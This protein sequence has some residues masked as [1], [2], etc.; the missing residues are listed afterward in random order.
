MTPQERISEIIDTIQKIADEIEKRNL[1]NE[2]WF[3]R[4]TRIYQKLGT[5]C[6]IRYCKTKE[7]QVNFSRKEKSIET[8][9]GE[10][11]CSVSYQKDV[12]NAV[13]L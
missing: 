5:D 4:T 13:M 9:G 1:E 7:K 12:K 6:K 3:S 11:S 10:I 8:I 2:N